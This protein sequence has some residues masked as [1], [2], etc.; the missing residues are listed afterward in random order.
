MEAALEAELARLEALALYAPGRNPHPG[1]IGFAD[2]PLDP[3]S[4]ARAE[5][6]HDL[7]RRDRRELQ[8]RL[9]PAEHD[10]RLVDGIFGPAT[11]AAIA[12]WQGAKGLPPTGYF[13]ERALAL[14]EQQT[15]DRF[16]AWQT[17]ENKRNRRRTQTAGL[18]S[19]VPEAA[20][21][22]A[23]C[24]RTW[25]GEIAYGQ[26]VLCD[27]RGLRENVAQLFRAS[28]RS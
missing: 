11:R 8:R 22:G 17:A 1:A 23:R 12:G 10:P 16:R 13:D 19:P 4:A 27:F 6:A 5:A 28:E 7:S 9:T 26:T 14:L 21:A 2:V 18:A 24:Q 25:S 3:A 20:P 15:E